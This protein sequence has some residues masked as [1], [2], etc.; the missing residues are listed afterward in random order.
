MELLGYRGTTG[1][2]WHRFQGC[3]STAGVRAVERG[4][5]L[6][7]GIVCTAGN[8]FDVAMGRL[9]HSHVPR[10]SPA[11]RVFPLCCSPPAILRLS[12]AVE[13]NRAKPTSR[14]VNTGARH[15]C[16]VRA[17]PWRSCCE[18]DTGGRKKGGE[19]SLHLHARPPAIP[20]KVGNPVQ[21]ERGFPPFFVD[22]NT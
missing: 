1:G 10:G 17:R 4:G 16:G 9:K 11:P 14:G 8:G 3:A 5:A 6:A 13:V 21:A 19:Y 12:F 15:V 20:S 18:S 22:Q 2:V 7:G